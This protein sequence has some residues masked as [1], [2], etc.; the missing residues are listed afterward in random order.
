MYLELDAGNSRIKWR[1]VTY[2]EDLA[3]KQ[4]SGVVAANQE[5]ASILAELNKHFDLLPMRDIDRARVSS[6]RG[7][8]F[9]V[10]FH[11]WMMEKWQLQPEFAKVQKECAGVVSAYHDVGKMGVD[12]WLAMLSAFQ[13]TEEGCCVVDCGSALT[14]DL[15][16]K[17]GKHQG[18]YI[19]PGLELMR[20]ALANKSAALRL[21]VEPG[22]H[23]VVPGKSTAE[24]VLNGIL[25]MAVA[26]LE[27]I[28]NSQG[29]GKIKWFLTGGDSL[30]I[31][32]QIGWRHEVLPDLV[33][34]GLALVLP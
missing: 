22:W 16:D 19:L 25:L 21:D 2:D 17:D 8:D 28:N 31:S 18:G 32:R 27:K 26:T 9:A 10:T 34:D 24:G 30:A 15:I 23:E 12:R 13:R 6:V 5:L 20:D 14:I 29:N 7:D 4:A 1:L 3:V 11:D 33:M